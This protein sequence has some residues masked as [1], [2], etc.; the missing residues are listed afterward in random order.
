MAQF[1]PKKKRKM[2]ASPAPAVRPEAELESRIATALGVAFPNI[3]RDQ[4]MQQRR[5]T[6]RLGHET[7]TFDSAAQWQK[8]GRADILIF[9]KE[10]PLA[11]LEVKREHLSLAHADYEQ[12]QS[13]ANQLTP[14]PPLVIVTNGHETR[15]YNANTGQDW[16]GGN[17]AAKAVMRLLANAATL[18][19]SDMRWATEALM[20]RETGVWTR[21]VR[22]STAAL[23]AEM[24]DQPGGAERPFARDLLF[25]RLTTFKAIEALQSAPTFTVIEGPP[26]IGKTSLL[27]ELALRTAD[28]EELAVLMLRGSGSGL[29]QVLANLFAVQLEWNLTA[30]DARQWL[31]RMSGGAAGPA[32]VVAIDGVDPGTAMAM[33]LEELASL[34]PGA[35]LKVILTTDQPEALV[36]VPNGRTKTALGAHATRIELGPLGLHEFKAAQDALKRTK[37][38]FLDG[39]EYA[40]DYR[41]PWVLR[42]IYD[43]VAR[44]PRFAD[45]TRG[46]LLPA[47]LGLQLVDAA[48]ETYTGQTELLHGYRLLARDAL[49][50]SEP[51]SAELALADSNGFIIRRDALSGEAQDSL[52]GLRAASWVRHYRHAGGEDVAVPTLPAAYLTELAEAAGDELGRRAEADPQAAGVWLGRR[53]EATYLGDLIGAQAIRSLADKTGG[54]RSGIIDGLLSIEPQ[55][56]LVDSALIA[57]ATPDGEL[58]HIKIENGKAWPPTVTARSMGKRSTLEPSGRACTP[59]RPRG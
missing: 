3:P 43:H 22:A 23:I 54:F 8:I 30:N 21:M 11:V 16:S 5:F 53:L 48:R 55:E 14:R 57:L 33:D 19:A 39:A 15:V 18:A 10:R 44:D 52:A 29:F 42:T 50:D 35:K 37:I 40:E 12:A 25:P 46:V 45:P 2:H 32:L 24:T 6:V 47:S 1:R 13:Y 34:R 9:Y 28:S 4:L 27:R 38:L 17:D 41:A 49:S 56:K 31:R 51:H 59:T 36:K 58:V 26:V 20:G 7:H